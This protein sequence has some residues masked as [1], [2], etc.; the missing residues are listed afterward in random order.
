MAPSS[1][2][3]SFTGEFGMRYAIQRA[4]TTELAH[5]SSTTDADVAEAKRFV[6]GSGYVQN[7]ALMR[8]GYTGERWQQIKRVLDTALNCEPDRRA[9]YLREACADDDALRREVG[10][11]LSAEGRAGKF[12]ESPPRIATSL[13]AGT[14]LGPY[15]VV[16]PIRAG[17][18]A[19]YTEAGTRDCNE[20]LRLKLCPQM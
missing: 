6:L 3:P 1:W 8:D 4:I 16:G 14:R 5:P 7:V 11:L 12:L 20:Q 15:E 18:M 17:G 19:R 10:S 9:G 13:T 2:V